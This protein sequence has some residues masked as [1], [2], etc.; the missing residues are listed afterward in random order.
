LGLAIARHLV[1]QHGGTLVARSE[2]EGK[3]ATFSV[4]LPHQAEDQPQH[5]TVKTDR[6]AGDRGVP[7]AN[8]LY[9]VRALLVDDED[10]SRDLVRT[11]LS[12]YG[13]RV[14]DASSADQALELLQNQRFDV[15]V[16]DIAMPQRDGYQL[17]QELRSRGDP[18]GASQIPAIALTAYARP[19]DRHK[20]LRL[21]YNRHLA[22]P[23][24]PARL[25]VE[26]L[27]LTRGQQNLDSPHNGDAT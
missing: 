6:K 27:R 25:V 19:S 2:G 20:A 23:V 13:A 4:T 11:V 21:G 15:L 7:T 12:Q 24:H 5:T 22:K 26:V 8:A 9:G 16:S 1:Q 14:Q 3:G 10:D 18:S 17:I